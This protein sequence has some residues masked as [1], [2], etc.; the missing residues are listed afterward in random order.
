MTED[1]QSITIQDMASA[2][3]FKTNVLSISLLGRRGVS[4]ELEA[5]P[6]LRKGNAMITIHERRGLNIADMYRPATRTVASIYTTT[7]AEDGPRS[8]DDEDSELYEEQDEWLGTGDDPYDGW[9][10]ARENDDDTQP[11]DD[12]NAAAISHAEAE[13]QRDSDQWDWYNGQWASAKNAE[14]GT[15]PSHETSDIPC[16]EVRS[17]IIRLLMRLPDCANDA[18]C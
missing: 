14:Y 4:V 6:C 12:A 10:D 8:Y 17:N 7:G 15:L 1:G 13:T 2:R 3:R 18:Q 16:V 9:L 11:H 5:N